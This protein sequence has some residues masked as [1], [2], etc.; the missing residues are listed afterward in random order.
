LLRSIAR[1]IGLMANCPQIG[2]VALTLA[3][4]RALSM[5][6]SPVGSIQSL[7]GY[8]GILITGNQ[9]WPRKEVIIVD[10]GSCD[11]TLHVARQF[12]SDAVSIVSQETQG[13]AAAPN[14]ACN[15]KSR[16]E[17]FFN[18][19]ICFDPRMNASCWPTLRAVPTF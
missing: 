8:I 19:E 17:P 3:D 14:S 4:E 11:Q 13:A 10:D 18:W 2:S 16:L 15:L 12:G 5:K 6:A 1:L 9:T 7:A